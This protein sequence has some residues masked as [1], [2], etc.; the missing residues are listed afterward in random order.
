VFMNFGGLET[1][2]LTSKAQATA[3]ADSPTI[4]SGLDEAAEALDAEDADRG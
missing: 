4:F 3:T 2:L 1:D